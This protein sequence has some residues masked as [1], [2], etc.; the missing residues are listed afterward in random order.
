MLLALGATIVK[1]VLGLGVENVK[2]LAVAESYVIGAIPPQTPGSTWLQA[3]KPKPPAT[4][5]KLNS[6]TAARSDRLGQHELIPKA[7]F[8][9]KSLW[10]LLEQTRVFVISAASAPRPDRPGQVP[11]RGRTTRAWLSDDDERSRWP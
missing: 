6:G 5:S 8:G 1:G 9:A 11:G 4:L 2:H 3:R 10:H 7:T